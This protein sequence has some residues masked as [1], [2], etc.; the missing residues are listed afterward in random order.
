MAPEAEPLAV[1]WREDAKPVALC[2]LCDAELSPEETRCPRCQSAVSLVHRCPGCARV[3]SA[4]H[5]RCPYCS[6]GF[7]KDK[8]RKSGRSPAPQ[9]LLAAKRHLSDARLREQRRSLQWFGAAVFLTVFA[10]AV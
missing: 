9:A 7:L 3:V 1:E 8:E 5:L 2:M 6:E 10:L 4:K